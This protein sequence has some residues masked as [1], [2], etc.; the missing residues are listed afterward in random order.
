M[1]IKCAVCGEPWEIYHVEHDMAPW[2]RALFKAG[3]G[4]ESCKGIA[5]ADADP[6]AAMESHLRS[7]VFG[8]H[9]DPDSF[10]R[11]HDPDGTRPEWK[12]PADVVLFKCAGCDS[13]IRGN[14]DFTPK[15]PDLYYYH[16]EPIDQPS[17]MVG[18]MFGGNFCYS[19]DSRFRE[20]C[21]YPIPI[22]DRFETVEAYARNCD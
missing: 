15:A 14:V 21:Q 7:V 6:D 19:S 1:D 20:I 11:L 5:S 10:A 12:R 4:C 8:G 16:A 22:H 9:A 3:A 2:A 18:P 17:G 13:E